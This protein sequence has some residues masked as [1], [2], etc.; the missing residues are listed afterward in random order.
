MRIRLCDRCSK[1]ISSKTEFISCSRIFWDKNWMKSEKVGDL[2]M[3]CYKQ[4]SEAK[5]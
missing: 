4:L 2:C 5:G 1:E 3:K